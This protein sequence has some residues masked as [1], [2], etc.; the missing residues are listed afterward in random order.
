MNVSPAEAKVY[1][2]CQIGALSAFAK[3]CGIKLSHVKPPGALYGMA[4]KDMRLAETLCEGIAEVDE[5]LILPR[6][7]APL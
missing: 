3:V 1:V 2:Q 5:S 7:P 6:F 4:W